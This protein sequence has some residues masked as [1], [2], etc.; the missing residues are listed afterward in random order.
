VKN[1]FVDEK[2]LMLK[3]EVKLLDLQI[4]EFNYIDVA[5]NPNRVLNQYGANYI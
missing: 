5:F 4:S 3:Y 2:Q 1:L